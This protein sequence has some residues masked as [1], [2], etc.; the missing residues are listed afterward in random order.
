[1]RYERLDYRTTDGSMYIDFGFC[2]RGLINGWRVYIL[3]DID[4]EGCNTSFHATHRLHD[5]GETHPYI[6]WNRRISSFEK[7]KQIASL[8]A[9]CTA[10]YIKGEGSFDAIAQQLLSK[11]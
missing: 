10:R 9:D 4:Y 5:S 6:C 7:A 11:R 8:W 2:N 3:E 1:M